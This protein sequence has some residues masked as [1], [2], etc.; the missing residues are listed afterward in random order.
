LTEVTYNFSS[1]T[2]VLQ[3]L[4]IL[5]WFVNLSFME[6]ATTGNIYRIFEG[7]LPNLF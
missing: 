3:I 2:N 4:V 1:L 6:Y 5:S 7:L